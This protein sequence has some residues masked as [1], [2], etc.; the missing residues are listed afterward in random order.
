VPPAPGNPNATNE[1]A[2]RAAPPLNPRR[3]RRASNPPPAVP[4]GGR[5]DVK[6]CSP[7][8]RR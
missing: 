7:D 2:P 1:R 5:A 3:Q 8:P 6:A 4:T